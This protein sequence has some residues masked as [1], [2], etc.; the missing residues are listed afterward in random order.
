MN[1]CD[2]CEH[3]RVF[4][5]EIWLK[6]IES[7][8]QKWHLLQQKSD[9]NNWPL[10]SSNWNV[11][12]RRVFGH[13]LPR[14]SCIL[15][16]C[17]RVTSGRQLHYPNGPYTPY[18]SFFCFFVFPFPPPHNYHYT[19]TIHTTHI[20][21]SLFEGLVRETDNNTKACVESPVSC[22][23]L[24]TETKRTQKDMWDKNRFELY[25]CIWKGLWHLLVNCVRMKEIEMV[26]NIT[27][28][29]RC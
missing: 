3:I 16:P 15:Y 19:T 22:R 4:F 2:Y 21:T 17:D 8:A 18:T 6:F 1:E 24:T 28:A 25:A 29:T 23:A 14:L 27:R 11:E 7:G 9:H 20:Q 13:L 5:Q 26:M 12:K 10:V